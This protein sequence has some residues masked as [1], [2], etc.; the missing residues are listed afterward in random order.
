MNQPNIKY[1]KEKSKSK[2]KKIID[3]DFFKSENKS[4]SPCARN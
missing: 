1:C 4:K 3:K 2:W